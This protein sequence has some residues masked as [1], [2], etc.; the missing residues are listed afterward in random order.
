[1]SDSRDGDGDAEDGSSASTSA[2]AAGNAALAGAGSDASGAACAVCEGIQNRIQTYLQD[3]RSLQDTP[4]EGYD[5]NF[6]RMRVTTHL[7]RQT[8]DVSFAMS[9]S[10]LGCFPSVFSLLCVDY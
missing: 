7:M 6:E 8:N 10:I 1:M 5:A 2:D 3:V 9:T 4:V